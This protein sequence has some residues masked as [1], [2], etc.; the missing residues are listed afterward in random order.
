MARRRQVRN[1]FDSPWKDALQRYFQDFLAF[2][3]PAIHADID[4][5]RGYDSLDKEFQQIVRR[6]KVGKGIADKLFKVWLLDGAE[7]WL[8]IHVEVQGTTTWRSPNGCSATT[9]RRMPCII[10]KWSAW[11]C[12][13]MPILPGGRRRSATAAGAA[14]PGRGS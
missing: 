14:G 1:D 9:W 11:R 4:W 13:A 10:A 7:C 8:L 2:F 12:C 5:T 6:A 3:Y